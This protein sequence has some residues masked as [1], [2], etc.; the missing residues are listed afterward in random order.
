[1][2]QLYLQDQG[3]GADAIL[4]VVKACA[5]EVVQVKFL[6]CTIEGWVTQLTKALVMAIGL[7]QVCL[8]PPIAF[9]RSLTQRQGTIDMS[10]VISVDTLTRLTTE[11]ENISADVVRLRTALGY[12]TT[13]TARVV[14]A[15]LQIASEAI[16]MMRLVHDTAEVLQL[17]VAAMVPLLFLSAVRYMPR[18]LWNVCRIAGVVLLLL[19]LHRNLLQERP[20]G[21]M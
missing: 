2:A 13:N 21:M 1:M 7:Y 19:Q 20:V 12:A 3:Y 6:Y 9:G 8:H 16:P 5:G 15:G 11:Y 17:V 10:T 14:V 18:V 4:A